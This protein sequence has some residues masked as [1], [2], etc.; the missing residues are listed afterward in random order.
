MKELYGSFQLALAVWGF[1]LLEPCLDKLFKDFGTAGD[2]AAHI[3]A[4]GVSAAAV[5]VGSGRLLNR[6]HLV[7]NW[8]HDRT[9]TA[10][11]TVQLVY[12]AANYGRICVYELKLTSEGRSVLATRLR[13]R[14]RTKPV[15]V[16]LRIDPDQVA[17][18]V[19]E[20]SGVSHNLAT[21]VSPTEV[22]FELNSI[23]EGVD[24]SWKEISLDAHPR[25]SSVGKVTCEYDVSIPGLWGWVS[26]ILMPVSSPVKTFELRRQ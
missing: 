17:M 10:G 21:V 6:P 8:V 16:R 26:S 19:E 25:S 11:P 14:A 24:I 4:V 2:I 13:R 5:F 18:I 12:P 23:S 7:L 3:I 20:M 15:V 22:C 9:E 1:L